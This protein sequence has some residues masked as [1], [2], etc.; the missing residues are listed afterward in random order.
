MTGQAGAPRIVTVPLHTGHAQAGRLTLCLDPLA[1]EIGHGPC[2]DCGKEAP[3]AAILILTRPDG[4][5]T[6]LGLC[7]DCL[8]AFLEKSS[9]MGLGQEGVIQ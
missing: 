8:F 1:D 9:H 3:A 6:A 5:M 7:S 2:E 4:A